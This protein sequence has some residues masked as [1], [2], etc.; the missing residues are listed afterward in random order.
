VLAAPGKLRR[1]SIAVL[2]DQSVP[3]GQQKSLKQVLAAAAGLDLAPP[4]QGGRGDRIELLPLPFDKTAAA[5]ETKAADDAAKQRFHA[6]MTRNGA[7]VLVVLLVVVASFFLARQLLAAP[8]EPLDSLIDEPV[9]PAA[10]VHEAGTYGPHPA[11]SPQPQAGRTVPTAERMR[12]LAS[13]R[14]DEVA[15]Q[16]QTWMAE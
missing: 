3:V 7:A 16:L 1:L 5:A 15:R 9:T 11:R 14:P 10:P 8:R 4:D 12:Q 13:Q 6:D 2:L